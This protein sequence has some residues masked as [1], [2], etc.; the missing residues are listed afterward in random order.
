[1]FLKTLKLWYRNNNLKDLT[2]INCFW[3]LGLARKRKSKIAKPLHKKFIKNSM[4]P[5]A[6]LDKQYRNKKEYFSSVF[7]FKEI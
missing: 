5:N 4:I 3:T 6:K 2:K 1:M 7:L